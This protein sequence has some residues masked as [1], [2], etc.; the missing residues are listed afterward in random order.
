MKILK[1]SNSDN[2]KILVNFQNVTH[3]TST[4][5]GS[6]IYT[7]KEEGYHVIHVLENLDEILDKIER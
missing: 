7:I 3:V 6:V 5:N 2:Q 1:L 4:E